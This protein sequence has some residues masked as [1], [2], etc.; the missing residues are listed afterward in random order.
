MNKK[1]LIVLV[2]LLVA[3]TLYWTRYQIVEGHATQSAGFY[4]INR[5]T[6]NITAISMLKEF[7]VTKYRH[8]PAEEPAP[9]PAAP[10]PIPTPSR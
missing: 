6:G 4:K 5:L 8:N 10:E 2:A 7:E 1:W 3:I 9:I